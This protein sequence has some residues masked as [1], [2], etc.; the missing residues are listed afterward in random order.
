MVP[1]TYDVH[2][3]GYGRIKYYPKF[4]DIQYVNYRREDRGGKGCKKNAKVLWT[5]YIRREMDRDNLLM[6]FEDKLLRLEDCLSFSAVNV[7]T[8][9]FS[10]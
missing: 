9:Q 5:S 10:V 1:S 8:A 2:T 7:H 6:T 3:G 4:A